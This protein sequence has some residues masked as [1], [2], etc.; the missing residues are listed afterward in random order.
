MEIPYEIWEKIAFCDVYAFNIL[1][2]AIPKLGRNTLCYDFQ[3]II[4]E[5]FK[6]QPIFEHNRYYTKINGQLHSIYD[7]PSYKWGTWI[8]EWNRNG[9][10]HRNG[11]KPAHIRG[12]G[13]KEWWQNGLRHRDNGPA[14]TGCCEGDEWWKHGEKIK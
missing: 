13:F 2:R 1:A 7:R 9:K 3:N 5:N 8:R 11:D 4:I 6:L 10:L 14:I 12:D